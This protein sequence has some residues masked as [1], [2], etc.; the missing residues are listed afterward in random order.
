MRPPVF[1]S[2]VRTAG[3][4]CS[5]YIHLGAVYIEDR[6]WMS[7]TER[8]HYITKKM[9]TCWTFAISVTKTSEIN[10]KNSK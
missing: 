7:L 8:K 6:K 5:L 3:K 9:K 1:G 2:S 4:I 10:V